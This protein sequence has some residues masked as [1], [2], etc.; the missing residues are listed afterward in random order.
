MSEMESIPSYLNSVVFMSNELVLF[1]LLFNLCYNL[2]QWKFSCIG[3][4]VCVKECSLFHRQIFSLYSISSV[5]SVFLPECCTT[6]ALLNLQ[7]I[8]TSFTVSLH[9]NFSHPL[10]SHTLER[11]VLINKPLILSSD[12]TSP[13][14]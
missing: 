3:L 1:L 2:L 4:F 6:W 12:V 14:L 10:K 9:L 11:D 7:N 5:M 8:F 13:L